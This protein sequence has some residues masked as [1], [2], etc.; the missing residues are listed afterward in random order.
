MKM[1]LYGRLSAP[2][3]TYGRETLS[4]ETWKSMKSVVITA[5]DRVWSKVGLQ[6]KLSDRGKQK[7]FFLHWEHMSGECLEKRV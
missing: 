2:T 7:T 1:E 6:I 3:L 5:L 4:F